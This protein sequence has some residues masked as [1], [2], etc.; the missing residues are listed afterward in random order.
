MDF[1]DDDNYMVTGHKDGKLRIWDLQTRK[2][3]NELRASPSEQLTSI[4]CTNFGHYIYT[5]ARDNKIYKLDT[6]KNSGPV[7]TFEDD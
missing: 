7:C 4:V 2:V 5:C 3:Q 6:R 1:A